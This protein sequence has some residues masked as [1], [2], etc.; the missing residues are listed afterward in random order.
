[1]PTVFVNFCLGTDS[2]RCVTHMCLVH[3]GCQKSYNMQEY[4][5][6][7]LLGRQRRVVLLG[8]MLGAEE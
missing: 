4:C 8:G 1:M 7:L 2:A 6:P 3:F 5:R